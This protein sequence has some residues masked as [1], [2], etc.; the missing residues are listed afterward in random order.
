M[1]NYHSL[2]VV[3]RSSETKLQVGENYRHS[4]YSMVSHWLLAVSQWCNQVHY[5][6]IVML[7]VSVLRDT[8]SEFGPS[9]KTTLVHPG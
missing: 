5:Q 6:P 9:T 1:G 4:V 2:E 7:L 8:S 3:G